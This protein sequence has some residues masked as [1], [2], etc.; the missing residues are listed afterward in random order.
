MTLDEAYMSRPDLAVARHLQRAGQWDLALAHLSATP[1]PATSSTPAT[2]RGAGPGDPLLAALAAEITVD[3]F[4]WQLGDVTP[5]LTAIAALGDT[6]LAALLTGQLTYWGTLFSL[7]LPGLDADPVKTFGGVL[8]APELG[9]WPLFWHAVSTENL[10]GDT[11]TA[12]AGYEKVRQWAR[13][14]GDVLLESYASR[15]LATGDDTVPLFRLSVQQRAAAGA[16]PQ[17]AAAQS[18]LADALGDTP[19][20]AE[21][22]ALV[23][24]TADE[25]GISWLRRDPSGNS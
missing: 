22:R 20:A 18:T 14:T 6:P 4:L 3:R 8:D 25:L 13:D 10:R 11:P 23:A 16:R 9:G 19:E 15:H 7:D 12:T 2:A 1:A 24:Y 17:L 5:A 21:L